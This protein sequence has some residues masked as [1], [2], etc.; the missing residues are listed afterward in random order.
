[1]E[2]RKVQL[3]GGST[4][5]I[6]L[7]KDWAEDHGINTDSVLFLYPQDDGTLQIANSHQADTD[8]WSRTLSATSLTL[9]QVH[10][11]LIALYAIGAEEI[12]I[13]DRT[14]L[15]DAVRDDVLDAMRGFAGLELIQAD[16]TSVTLQSVAS[17]KHVDIRKN[18]LRLRLVTLSMYQDAIAALLTTDTDLA[19]S[20]I[21]RDAEADK[22]FALLTRHFRRGISSLEEVRQLEYSRQALFEYYYVGRQLERVAD[23]AER[24]AHLTLD[25]DATIP[26]VFREDVESLADRA[27]RSLDTASE[28]L[29]GS[30]DIETADRVLDQHDR[31][32]D[33]ID[34]LDRTL[35][36]HEEAAEAHL[37]G[38]LLDSIRRTVAYSDNIARILLQRSLR[39]ADT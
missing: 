13:R 16:D 4:Y 12:T 37:V 6:S 18:T 36:S 7:P 1:M 17:P 5:T 29:V 3:S 38:R 23:H 20:V 31:L 27:E 19:D 32:L 9:D 26:E 39:Q 8:T 14:G 11:R 30:A 28:V 22:L 24:I 25:V 10:N 35:Y 15:D 2:T 33:D 34:A 21:D